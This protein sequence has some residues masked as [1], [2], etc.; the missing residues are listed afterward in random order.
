MCKVG[1]CWDRHGFCVECTGGSSSPINGQIYDANTFSGGEYK[2][3]G[4]VYTTTPGVSCGVLV[5]TGLYHTCALFTDIGQ[6][7]CWGSNDKGQLGGG[8]ST[9]S[10]A[11]DMGSNLPFVNF[12]ANPNVVAMQTGAEYTCVLFANGKMKCFGNNFRC[13]LGLGKLGGTEHTAAYLTDTTSTGFA[14][15]GTGRTVVSMHL[16]NEHTCVVLDNK[17]VKCF[18][19][20]GLGQLGLGDG[21]NRGCYVDQM[22]DYLPALDFGTNRYAVRVFT[23]GRYST[24]AL[25]NTAELKCWGYNGEYAL[26]MGISK[27]VNIGDNPGEM[28]DNLVAITL[29]T[30]K[31]VVD[32]CIGQ[33]H[34]CVVTD[35]NQVKC[36]G[37]NY[38]GQL[39]LGDNNNRGDNAN[40]MDNYLP[41][42][43]LG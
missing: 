3:Q 13:Q 38:H 16:G 8:T 14:N 10:V 12:G 4:S 42:V 25:L 9:G 28:G 22:G 19:S 21:V 26:G 40:E 37:G 23:S 6:V 15:V 17:Q 5:S 41:A 31:T 43:D 29:P 34:F 30:G 7:K 11:A 32:L 2:G 24:C 27:D 18:G 20:N 1:L 36:W 39:G 35:T 33:H